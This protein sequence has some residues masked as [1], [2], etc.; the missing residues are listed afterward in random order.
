[1]S[2]QQQVAQLLV[3][4]TS[5]HLFDQEIRYPQWEAPTDTLRHWIQ[6]LGVGGV[7]VLGGSTA[8][9]EARIQH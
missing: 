2:L 4:R 1:M 7:I 8:E 6:D 3:V 9:L 5:G